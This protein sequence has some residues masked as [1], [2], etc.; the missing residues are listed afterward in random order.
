MNNILN[1]LITKQSA[2]LH[3]INYK[4][5]YSLTKSL[6]K[7]ICYI[8]NEINVNH[9]VIL[10]NFVITQKLPLIVVHKI[11]GVVNLMGL[12][13]KLECDAISF[14]IP[15]TDVLVASSLYIKVFYDPFSKAGYGV[16]QRRFH[17]TLEFITTEI[18]H[19]SR[20]MSPIKSV[21]RCDS[22]QHHFAKLKLK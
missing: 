2:K 4:I 16:A 9:F 22:V 15:W 17:W 13:G 10:K 5:R 8:K 11:V 19:R 20:W 18:R 1:K 14:K 12:P 21:V 7:S 3:F 6:Q